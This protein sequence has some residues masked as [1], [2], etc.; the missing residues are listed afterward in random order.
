M[1]QK[2]SGS[3]LP[4]NIPPNSENKSNSQ[5][6]RDENNEIKNIFPMRLQL[7]LARCGVAS[8]RASEVY[9]TD[10]RVSINDVIQKELG[11]KVVE[12]D[13][14]RVDG[15]VISM[16]EK[17]RYILLNKPSGYIC[18]LSDEKNRPIA[19]SLLSPHFKER[20]YN[21]GRLDM[22]SSG[23]IIFTNDG[24]FTAKV[25]HP[26]SEIEK[27]YIVETSLPI[28]ND[29][30]QRF[31][32]GMRVG[33]VFYKCRDAQILGMYRIRVVLIEGKNR[34]I[35]RVFDSFEIG[36]KR[37]TRI[38]IGPLTIDGLQETQFRELPKEDIESIIQS[39][40]SVEG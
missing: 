30:A 21:V 27:E 19:A 5:P 23:L 24:E 15:I 10:G 2:V 26:S 18:S 6:H 40:K 36:I 3:N 39:C 22:Y 33:G 4:D 11:T 28:P 31:M 1:K 14:V 37:L 13:I 32:K 8:R 7:Y 35:R 16:E 12:G 9:I 20:L 29:L 17:K 38:R 34:E 25:S